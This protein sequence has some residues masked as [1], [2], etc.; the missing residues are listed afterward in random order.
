MNDYETTTT[1]DTF[2]TVDDAEV[3]DAEVV[4]DEATTDE[5]VEAAEEAETPTEPV[6]DEADPETATES[7]AR[8]G[9][10]ALELSIKEVTDA[11]AT[12]QITLGEGELLT[13]HRI[14]NEIAKRGEPKPSPGAVA[15]CLGRW[16]DVGYI[17]ANEKPFAFKD[18]TE[19]AVNEGLAALKAAASERRK[20]EKAAAKAEETPEPTPGED[21][22][23]TDEAAE[24][25]E[26]V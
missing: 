23:S 14:A 17:V 24:P 19:A 20:A 22:A 8:R 15:A 13:P 3:A 10:G 2:P 4:E 11:Y 21:E 26:T 12:G 18:Y 25:A 1:D 16:L 5:V 6:N 9:R 7:A